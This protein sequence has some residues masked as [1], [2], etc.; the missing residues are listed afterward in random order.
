[1]NEPESILRR[2]LLSRIGA[3]L[4]AFALGA[5]LALALLPEWRTGDPPGDRLFRESYARMAREAGFELVP[6]RPSVLLITPRNLFAAAYKALGKGGSPWLAGSRTAVVARVS[7]G[8]HRPGMAAGVSFEVDF[9]LDGRPIRI[10]WADPAATPF[11]PTDREVFVRLAKSLARLLPSSGESL[12][13]Y[14]EEQIA[15]PAVT[16]QIDL[17]GSVPQQHVELRVAPPQVVLV[18]RLPG[19]AEN[20]AGGIDS[21]LFLEVAANALPLLLI[22]ISGVIFLVLL[23]QGRI[24]LLNGAILALITFASADFRSLFELQPSIWFTFIG[25]LAAAPG[26]AL[27]VFLVWSAGE[28][29]L[30]AAHPDFTTSLDTLRLGRLGPRGGRAL[31]LGLGAGTALAGLRLGVYALAV[32]LPGLSPAAPSVDAPVF[33][34][35]GSPVGT[36][37]FLAAG[38][39]LALA[40]SLRFLPTRWA[41][42]TAALL[43]G[44]ALSPLQLTP[45]PAELALNAGFAGLLIWLCRRRG[46]TALLT[47]CVVSLL[48]PAL[49]FSALHARWMPVALAVTAGLILAIAV[50]GLVGLSRPEG[51]ETGALPT[52]AFV[53]R[54]AEERRLSHEVDLLARMQVG[55][56]PREMPRVEGWQIAARS[57]LA[58]EAGGDLYDFLRDESGRLWIAA[59]DVAG[60]GYSCAVMQAMVKA[61]LMSL[62]EPGE[63]PAR[64]L[65]QLDRVLRTAGSDHS[66]TS[67]ALLSLDPAT[68]EALLGNA[69]HPYPMVFAAGQVTEVALPGLPLGQGPVRR[70]E[71]RPFSLPPRSVLLLCSDGLFEAL[72]RNGNAYGFERAREVLKAMGHRPPPEIVD[73]LLNDCRRH[74][75]AEEPPDDVTVVVVKRS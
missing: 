69:G 23:V 12:G 8:V 57:V 46:L 53:R 58:H 73:A 72:D 68:G 63:T 38:V 61:G 49:L 16:V 65:T 1:M 50:Q 31:L 71:D 75:G 4:A 18:R 52:P 67:L 7:H 28:S 10:E 2:R 5:G 42:G 48:L 30:R 45:F 24:G 25:L 51:I 56:L 29:L 14:P 41:I 35:T 74:L 20:P 9:S 33:Q 36:G 66:F 64:V 70:Y 21:R 6:G 13:R 54:L 62:I 27:L 32:L 34:A 60:H 19:R 44:Y 3:G 43:A 40:V 26:R 17:L 59:G 55:L 39:A 15:G 11:Q 47:A 22:V 37:I